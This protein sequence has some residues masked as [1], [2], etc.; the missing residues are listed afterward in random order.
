MPAPNLGSANRVASE[1]NRLATSSIGIIK[2]TLHGNILKFETGSAALLPESEKMLNQIA[3]ALK[4][5]PDVHASVNGYTDNVGSADKNLELSR[6]RANS[7]MVALVRRGIS[8]DRLTAEGH[9][10]DD[11]VADN[12]TDSGRA[13]NRRV[14]V[15]VSQP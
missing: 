10:Q 14:A 5:Y 15:D 7:V 3:S 12:S 9:G 8:P 2:G 4:D 11:P 1:A 6:Q 13:E